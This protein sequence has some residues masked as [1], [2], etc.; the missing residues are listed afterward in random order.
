MHHAMKRGSPDLAHI[1]E[2]DVSYSCKI[3][4]SELPVVEG[5]EEACKLFL[6]SWDKSKI[7]LQEQFR[8]MLLTNT[9]GCLG[10]AT[11]ST[12]GLVSCEVDLKLAFGMALK[13]R[14]RHIIIAHNHPSGCMLPSEQDKRLTERFKA[15]GVLLDTPLTDHLIVTRESYLSFQERGLL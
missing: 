9:N 3:P 5:P 13:A 2:I 10:I 8:V 15:A 11:L 7:E 1:R 12:G 4:P 14:A 6:E